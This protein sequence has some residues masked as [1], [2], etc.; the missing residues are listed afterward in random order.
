MSIEEPDR[1]AALREEYTREGLHESDLHPDPTELLRSWLD[2]AI[3]SGLYDPTA[4]VLATVGEDGVPAARMV[5]LKGLSPRGLAFFTNYASRKGREL[6]ARASCALVFPWHPLQRQVRVEGAVTRLSDAENDAYFARRP[7]GSQLGAWASPQ[8]R[9]VSSRADLD[10][11]YA[12]A[13]ERFEGR[14]VSRP[15]FWG[16]YRVAPDAVEFW[17][18]RGRRMHDRF[19]YRRVAADD[20]EFVRLAP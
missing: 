10:Q 19:R 11:R 8:S 9:E 20:W 18:G 4:M 16:G 7:R 17:Q 15:P 2:D 3:D 6:D 12:D 14:E 13:E 5:L 1:I